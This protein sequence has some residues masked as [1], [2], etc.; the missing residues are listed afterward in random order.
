MSTLSRSNS[1]TC[2]SQ[3]TLLFFVKRL[4]LPYTVSVLI[5]GKEKG[6]QVLEMC[7]TVELAL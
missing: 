2:F 1:D 6:V 7:R 4:R 3:A 5:T